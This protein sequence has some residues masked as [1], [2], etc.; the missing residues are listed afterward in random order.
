MPLPYLNLKVINTIS[1]GLYY[2]SHI[3]DLQYDQNRS[4]TTR[5][6]ST[7]QNPQHIRFDNEAILDILVGY[8]VR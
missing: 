3:G 7:I 6:I 5:G 2:M 1:Y 8:Y 4:L